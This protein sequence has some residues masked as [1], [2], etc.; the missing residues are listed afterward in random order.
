MNP[1][2]IYHNC[3]HRPR[4]HDKRK[5]HNAE[6]TNSVEIGSKS[7]ETPRRPFRPEELFDEALRLKERAEKAEAEVAEL[8]R[9]M[10]GWKQRATMSETD[11]EAAQPEKK[12]R[13]FGCKC[14]SLSVHLAGDGCDE[15]NKAQAIEYLTESNE[16]LQ[17]EIEKLQEILKQTLPWLE[18][19]ECGNTPCTCD[20]LE[21][22]IM[23]IK[24]L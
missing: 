23:D 3:G 19:Y 8:N 6:T 11:L 1:E 14:D 7:V 24:E 2:D 20:G 10:V 13:P 15:C 21:E 5:R 4:I 17:A 22:L 18:A 16:E 9:L 12:K